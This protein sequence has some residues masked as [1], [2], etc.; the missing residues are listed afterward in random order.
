MIYVR[1]RTRSPADRPTVLST[2]SNREDKLH[3]TFFFWPGR[4]SANRVASGWEILFPHPRK[5]SR[6]SLAN[7]GV[8][9]TQKPTWRLVVVTFW[10]GA[11]NWTIL[12]VAAMMKPNSVAP[13][14]WMH[15][16]RISACRDKRVVVV[17]VVVSPNQ[18]VISYGRRRQFRRSG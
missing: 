11:I 17:V 4:V 6:R 10:I 12:R 2:V 14:S 13:V 15:T 8:Q 9:E 18:D 16:L 7:R 5:G 3:K 1:R